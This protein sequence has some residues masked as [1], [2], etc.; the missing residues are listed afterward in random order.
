MSQ[1]AW[2]AYWALLSSSPLYIYQSLPTSFP[3]IRQLYA[4]TTTTRQEIYSSTYLSA[5]IRKYIQASIIELPRFYI[6]PKVYKSPWASRPIVSSHSLITSRVAEVVDYALQPFIPL[7]P[8]ILSSSKEVI[9]IIH[10]VDSFADCWIIT[11][12]VKAMYTDI[13]PFKA[14]DALRILIKQESQKIRKSYLTRM[15]E[16]VLL[17]SLFTYEN[18]I[19][20]LPNIRVSYGHCLHTCNS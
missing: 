12:D 18:S 3:L 15:K 9:E 19:Y 20:Y 2:R 10:K 16:L 17:N 5:I 8:S 7:F 11:G 4:I 13:D 1:R 14:I 6:I